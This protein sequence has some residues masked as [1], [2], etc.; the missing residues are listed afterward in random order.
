MSEKYAKI[1]KNTIML[2][3]TQKKAY[4]EK[5]ESANKTRKKNQ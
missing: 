2:C 1:V 3:A 5:N 4:V